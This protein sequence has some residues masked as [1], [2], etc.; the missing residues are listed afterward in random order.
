MVVALPVLAG[1]PRVRKSGSNG[2]CGDQT[3]R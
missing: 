2:M 3:E 1:E